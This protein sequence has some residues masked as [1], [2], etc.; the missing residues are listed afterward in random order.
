MKMNIVTVLILQLILLPIFS[1]PLTSLN[2]ESLD[3][4]MSQN[5]KIHSAETLC[6]E[7]LDQINKGLNLDDIL[8]NAPQLQIDPQIKITIIH[9]PLKMIADYYCLAVFNKIIEPKDIEPDL[10]AYGVL[11]FSYSSES[12]KPYQQWLNSK[13]S[14]ACKKQ[15]EL[16]KITPTRLKSA[17]PFQIVINPKTFLENGAEEYFNKSIIK[18]YNHER[19]HSVF[20][21]LKGKSKVLK[22]WNSLSKSE[23]EEFKLE[24]PGYN[25]KNNDVILREFFSYTFETH[26]MKAYDFLSDKY[27]P[28]TYQ[29]LSKAL[30]LWCLS[31][32]EL[33]LSKIRELTLL[34][35]KDLLARIEKEGIKV[36]ILKAG[37]KNPGTFFTWGQIRVDSGELSE[38]TKLEGVMGKTLCKN[39]KPESKDGLTIVLSDDAPYSI[40]AHEYLHVLQIQRDSTW[41]P[42][43]KRLWANPQPSISDQRMKHDR[44]WDVNL[45]LWQLL[46]TPQLNMEDQIGIADSLIQEAHSRKAYDSTAQDFIVKN[47]VDDYL[48]KKIVEYQLLLKNQKK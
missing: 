39:E 43:S 5:C 23:K 17:K 34:P 2:K 41:C 11:A 26:P 42:I 45:I 22:F 47:K 12:D 46:N 33:T 24:H 15:L 7:K 1:Q 29:Q 21:L 25:Y 40:L 30:C 38:I 44:E 35:P 13:N 4:L 31:E 3:Q 37:R 19:L 27:Q 18:S 20:A 10:F 6:K 36:L 9:D 48:G 8:I 16:L 14:A 28:K 32:D